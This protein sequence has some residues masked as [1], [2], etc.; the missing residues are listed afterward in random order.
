MA[1]VPFNVTNKTCA[2]CKWW[3][4]AR[5]VTFA[6]NSPLHVKADTAPAK[7]MAT[8]TLPRGPGASCPRYQRWEKL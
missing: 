5:E 2:T 1:K 3:C 8:P 6:V 7:C 4:G